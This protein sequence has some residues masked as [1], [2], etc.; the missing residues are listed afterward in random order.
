MA[1]SIPVGAYAGV[2]AKRSERARWKAAAQSAGLED[3]VLATGLWSK[4]ILTARSGRHAVRIEEYAHS[5]YNRGTRVVVEGNSGLTLRAEKDVSAVQRVIGPR[6]MEI[7][8]EQFDREV[9][10]EGGDPPVLRAVLDVETRGMVR[11]F[12]GG[13]LHREGDV[14]GMVASMAAVHDG[15]VVFEVQSIRD[16]RLRDDFADLIHGPLVLARRL[17]RPASVVTRLV[18]NTRQEPHPVMRLENFKVLARTFPLHPAAR[19]LFQGGCEDE[20]QE[21][22][23]H[24][25]LGLGADDAKGGATLLEIAQRGWSDDPLAARA[26]LTLGPRLP[27]DAA[28]AILNHALRAR[29]TETARACLQVL[30]ESGLAPAVEPLVKVL[31]VEKG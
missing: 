20:Q 11:R 9:F 16:M 14:G 13:L 5:K 30:G 15:S 8:D 17:E 4:D 1:L 12:L 6:E 22:Q 2:R 18:E 19:E 31:R 23:L 24:S 7:G 3:I 25:A 21:I 28:T 10:V 26:V 27:T 29:S